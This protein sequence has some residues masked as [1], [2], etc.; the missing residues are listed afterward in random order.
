MS[1]R[2]KLCAALGLFAVGCVDI[3]TSSDTAAVSMPNLVVV[4]F[5]YE[6]SGDEYLF[7]ALVENQGYADADLFSVDLY[8]DRST[9]PRLIDEGDASEV[10]LTGVSQGDV[11]EV[12]FSVSEDLVESGN[13][14]WVFVDSTDQIAEIYEDDNTAGPTEILAR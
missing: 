4:G 8:L 12:N 5:W 13:L 9:E 2:T 10:V 1:F 7:T 14:T 6:K 11:V 3:A